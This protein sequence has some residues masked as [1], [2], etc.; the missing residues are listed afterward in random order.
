MKQST[1][2]HNLWQIMQINKKKICKHVNDRESAVSI[3][4]FQLFQH[5]NMQ[6]IK[7]YSKI[8]IFY[9]Y[10]SILYEQC[11][12]ERQSLQQTDVWD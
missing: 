1:Y 3:V 5:I 7:I 10:N 2:L 12:K 6:N 4:V 8:V 11:K 9:I